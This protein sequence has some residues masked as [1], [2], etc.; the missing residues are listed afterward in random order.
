MMNFRI[1]AL[2]CG[3]VFTCALSNANAQK[4]SII[5]YNSQPVKVELSAKGSIQS[6]I[7]VVPDYM[8]GYDL[9]I[10]PIEVAPTVIEE[11]VLPTT[12][13][14]AKYA[15]VSTEREELNYKPDFATL[16][17]KAIATLN[18]IAARLKADPNVKILLTAHSTN[19]TRDKLTDNRLN[20]AIGYLGIKG[21]H[22]SR[23]QTEVQVGAT[24]RDIV[25]INYLN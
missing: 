5:L 25:A 3:I 19:R 22:A 11:P 2:L 20:S 17:R 9:V 23:I 7:S 18:E 10:D 1:S 24:M 16:D 15:I 14:N 13:Q 4:E 12:T 8:A 21:I 6:F